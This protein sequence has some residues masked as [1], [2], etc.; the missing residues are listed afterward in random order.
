VEGAIEED[1]GTPRRRKSMPRALAITLGSIVLAVFLAVVWV[2]ANP[3]GSA[4]SSYP[5]AVEGNDGIRAGMESAEEVARAFLAEADP[6]KRLRWVRDAEAV[7]GR[8]TDYPSAALSEPGEIDKI[9]GHNESAT[10]FAVKL[11]SDEIRLLEVVETPDG[12]RVDWDAYARHGTASWEDLWSGEAQ[13]AVVRVFCEPSTEKP[14]PFDDPARW[15]GFRLGSPDMGQVALA[16]AEVGTVRE[17]MMKKVVLASPRFRQRFTLEVVRHEGEDEPLFEI[18]KCVAVGWIE[19][20]RAIE[21]QWVA[22]AAT[23]AE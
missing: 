1:W 9:I 19:G 11:P 10:A 5:A 8:L 21:D 20:E 2:L 7:R 6:G 18:T 3:G 14:E 4:I 23:A 22:E 15:T 16:F 13:R 12:P 17:A